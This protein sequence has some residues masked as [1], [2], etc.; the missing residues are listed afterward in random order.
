MYRFGK[1]DNM[2]QSF[3]P[4]FY[5]ASIALILTLKWLALTPLPRYESPGQAGGS[6]ESIPMSDRVT[7]YNED[8]SPSISRRPISL[9]I[10]MIVELFPAMS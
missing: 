7:L 8:L 5:A 2:I 1:M 3:F 4:S 9:C 10:F 6:S